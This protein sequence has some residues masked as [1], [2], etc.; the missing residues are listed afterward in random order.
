VGVGRK[1]KDG[2]PLGLEKRVEF[3][4]GQF[5][6][7][8]ADGTKEGLGTDLEK[9]NKRA[10]VYNDPEGR[11][12]T[13]G[14][15]LDLFLAAARAGLLPAG[16]KLG[17]RTIAD[18]DDEAELLKVSPLGKMFPADLVREPHLI[19]EY[20]DKRVVDGKGKVQANHA[21]SLLS[22]TYRWLIESPEHRLGLVV[23]PVTLIRRFP[24]RP[25]DRYVEDHDFRA[26]YAIA[27][28]SVRMAMDVI[29]RTLQRPADVLG[30]PP[31]PVRLKAVAGQQKRV[32]P[33][34]QGK[35]GRHVDIEMTPELEAAFAMLAPA[36]DAKVVK[37]P[38]AL[39]HGRA[40]EPYTEDGIASMLRRYCIK[41]KVTPFGL[42]DVRAKGATDMYLDNV[43]LAIIQL[44]MAHKSVQTTEI[45]IKRLLATISTVSPNKVKMG[46]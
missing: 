3:H 12:G 36:P 11:Y 40:G 1:R 23:N 8:H 31:A 9:A 2:N 30:L 15:Y 45:Y 44:L 41:A 26:V 20:R 46:Q 38:K 24:R 18:Y 17:D 6:Y 22:S 5:R 21:L 10:R 7:L 35:R 37:L 16:W 25:K 4:H 27:I 32:L 39:I 29:Y 28:P 19:A 13:V 14:Y 42:M 33:V 43:A 34:T